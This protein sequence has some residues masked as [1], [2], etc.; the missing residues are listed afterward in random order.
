MGKKLTNSRE[1][2]MAPH[3]GG[4]SRLAQTVRQLEQQIAKLR[5]QAELLALAHLLACGVDD[6][7]IFWNRGAE[8]LYGWTKA[9][10]L[11]FASHKLLQTVYPEPLEKIKAKLFRK[12][13]WE[14]EL[15]HTRKDGERITVASHWVLHRDDKGQPVAILEANNDITGRKRIEE[16]LQQS[17]RRHRLLFETMLQG[18]VYQDA[19]GKVV[20]TNPA[21]EAILGGDLKERWGQSSF[22]AVGRHQRKGVLS[23]SRL[24]HPSMVALRTGREVKDAILEVYNPQKKSVR[25]ISVTA[26]PLFKQGE[27]KPYHVYT[28][29][30]DITE[31]KLSEDKQSRLASFPERNPNPVVEVDF[32]GDSIL[33][34]NPAARQLFPDMLSQGVCHPWLTGLKTMAE[35]LR[36][37]K[38]ASLQREVR[39]GQNL[40]QQVVSRPF[41]DQRV[42]V[43]GLNITDRERMREALRKAHDELEQ[44]VQERTAELLR[45]NQMLRMLSECNLALARSTDETQLMQAIC[46]V[47]HFAGYPRAWVGLAERDK[48]KTV[49]PVASA[50]FEEGY[51]KRFHASWGGGGR[52]PVGT[53]IR[54]GCPSLVDDVG[55]RNDSG[56]WRAEAAR[57][58]VGS[59]ISLPLCGGEHVFG[60]LTLE[61]NEPA[62]FDPHIVNLLRELA[63]NLAY[64]ITSLRARTER[65]VFMRELNRKTG[66]LR[67]LASELTRAE[68]RE[69]RRLSQVL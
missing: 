36:P 38:A 18:V 59:M 24:E 43:Y 30:D 5:E 48:A 26:V 31:R 66:Q 37:G 19:D 49:L 39:V 52:C 28:I 23:Y 68:Q 33:Y 57:R 27:V 15:I 46:Q 67:A 54:T 69:R 40:Y 22:A 17:E 9:E 20:S 51:F 55:V 25:W 2:D 14:G 29:F 13:S 10:A 63:D 34:V 4:K 8:R 21:A 61:A 35:K 7:I 1:P 11:G 3:Q 56:T 60:A 12:G 41:N 47:I 45:A 6:R 62:A 50:G 44:K 42:R 53:A 16:V 65:D 58:G 64:G 32:G